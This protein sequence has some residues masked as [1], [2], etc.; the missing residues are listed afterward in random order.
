MLS[1]SSAAPIR[2]VLSVTSGRG[3]DLATVFYG[4]KAGAISS[5]KEE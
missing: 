3:A 1:A 4:E 5:L 2:L